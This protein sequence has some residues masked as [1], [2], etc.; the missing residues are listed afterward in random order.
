MGW[1][2][3]E[4]YKQD[5]RDSTLSP[6]HNWTGK[7]RV[8]HYLIAIHFWK[9]AFLSEVSRERYVASMPSYYNECVAFV[10]YNLFITRNFYY[11][12]FIVYTCTIEAFKGAYLSYNTINNRLIKLIIL[13]S[14][15]ERQR[16][17]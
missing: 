2:M 5:S 15:K 13:L 10:S 6:L 17:L 4:E 1:L 11:I 9:I 16:L 12:K 7:D 8:H 14:I 3:L